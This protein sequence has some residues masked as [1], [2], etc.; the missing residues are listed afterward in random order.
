VTVLLLVVS[1]APF[2]AHQGQEAEEALHAIGLYSEDRFLKE[3]AEYK[4]VR[5]FFAIS[6]SLESGLEHCEHIPQHLLLEKL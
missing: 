1:Q 6:I 2:T 5:W 3:H 4:R